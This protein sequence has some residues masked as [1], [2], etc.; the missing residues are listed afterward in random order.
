MLPLAFP[1]LGSADPRTGYGEGGV[2]RA[3]ADAGDG[4]RLGLA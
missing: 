3:A 2:D 4:M 1:G